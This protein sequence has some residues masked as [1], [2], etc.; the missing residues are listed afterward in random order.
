MC[1]VC[2]QE[3]TF[4]E[5]SSFV[6]SC[7]RT[8]EPRCRSCAAKKRWSSSEFR[9]KQSQL[10]REKWQEADYRKKQ[11]EASE[12][13]W[14][15]PVSRTNRLKGIKKAWSNP[16]VRKRASQSALK[17]WQNPE[18]QRQHAEH[19]ARVWADSSS[20]F[21]QP[22]FRE[23]QSQIKLRQYADRMGVPYM[24]KTRVQLT[25]KEFFK[26]SSRVKERDNWECQECGSTEILHAHH[27]KS[28]ACYPELAKDLD[29]GITLCEL[30][31]AKKH[32]YLPWMKKILER[33]SSSEVV[34]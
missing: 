22:E 7:K 32:P 4:T 6:R 3:I 33:E 29:N 13:A 20:G 2:G 12:A 1:V 23:L 24:P 18:R 10:L 15:N 28:R 26:W 21:N 16:D 5:K 11:S 19:M 31:H 9:E 8:D 27:I 25:R 14:K 17:V 30:C 34:V